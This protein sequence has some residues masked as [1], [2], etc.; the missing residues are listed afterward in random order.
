L[1]PEKTIDALKAAQLILAYLKG[2]PEKAKTDTSSMFAESFEDV[3]DPNMVTPELLVAAHH[4]FLDIEQEKHRAMLTMRMSGLSAASIQ[5]DLSSYP[6][7]VSLIA[8]AMSVVGRYYDN[9]ERVAA[10]RLFRSVRAR[11]DLRQIV[12]GV[13]VNAI[14][15]K[16]FRFDFQG[17]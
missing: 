2:I 5:I 6:L 1:S 4:I 12:E 3:F 11:Q 10:Y 8:E 14:Q 7:C 15:S 16:Q 17:Q 9:I 13:S